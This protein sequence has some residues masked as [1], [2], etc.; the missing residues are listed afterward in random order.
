MPD[1]PCG[2]LHLSDFSGEA[3][4]AKPW[5]M[6]FNLLA[7]KYEWDDAEKCLQLGFHLSGN[8]AIW[9][10][11]LQEDD[12]KTWNTLKSAF[13]KQ[14]LDNEPSLVTESRLQSR[15]LSSSE[16]IEEYYASILQLGSKLDRQPDHLTT[17][18]LNGLPDAMK[19]FIIGTDKHTMD[20]YITRARLYLARHPLKSV[21]FE[22]QFPLSESNGA[23]GDDHFDKLKEELLDVASKRM[24]R[25]SLP[26]RPRT[27]GQ[28]SF[29]GRVG[30]YTRSFSPSRGFRGGF[31][32][33]RGNYR[34][35]RGNYG[36]RGRGN[37]FAN[38]QGRSPSPVSKTRRHRYD[39]NL[40]YRC[41]S[42]QHW[43]RNC[44]GHLND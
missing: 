44:T 32:R 33:G 12:A 37:N 17:N 5:Y 26:R 9:F 19:D 28:G 42:N 43:A 27:R 40:C 30:G 18:F 35:G 1:P 10:S 20:N 38:R 39:N 34:T 31:A 6:K 11:S 24:D 15:T 14:F 16:T 3:I 25:L 13:E 21:R 22:N 7:T 8:A 36:G 41:E 23:R 2:R 29:R 4:A